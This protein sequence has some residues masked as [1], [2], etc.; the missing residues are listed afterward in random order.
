MVSQLF[1]LRIISFRQSNSFIIRTGLNL[2]LGIVMIDHSQDV[3]KFR[4][5]K[6]IFQQTS[7]SFIQVLLVAGLRSGTA[8]GGKSMLHL[9]HF[10]VGHVDWPKLWA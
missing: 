10:G 6:N 5:T 7:V 9:G 1:G 2:Q 3:L 8:L 4:W